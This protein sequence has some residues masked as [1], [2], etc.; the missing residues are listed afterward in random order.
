MS[1]YASNHRIFQPCPELLTPYQSAVT[2]K[3]RVELFKRAGRDLVERNITDFRN[4]LIVYSLLVGGLRV[5]LQR[6]LAIGLLPEV[7]PLAERH[8]GRGFRCVRT[9][10]FFEPPPPSSAA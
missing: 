3:V 5:F 9:D 10:F 4:D 7:H 8:I 6:R 1:V 2:F